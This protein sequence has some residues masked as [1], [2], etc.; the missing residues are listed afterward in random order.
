MEANN[1]NSISSST[2]PSEL[3]Q[4]SSIPEPKLELNSS[5]IVPPSETSPSE[6]LSDEPQNLDQN[7]D[8]SESQAQSE[9][10][11]EEDTS[12]NLDA[13]SKHVS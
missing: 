5:Q 3:S 10:K 9:T 4:E 11:T 6:Q 13:S 7:Q 1:N 2:L 8:F 12:L